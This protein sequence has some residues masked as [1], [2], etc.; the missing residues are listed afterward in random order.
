MSSDHIAPWVLVLGM[1]LCLGAC[2]DVRRGEYWREPSGTD[3]SAGEAEADSAG[4][5]DEDGDTG[6]T[7]GTGPTGGTDGG[8]A[9]S[10]GPPPPSFASDVLPL[11]R[12]DC[13]EC[14]SAGG[15]ASDSGYL[16]DEDDQTIYTTTLELVDLDQPA[17]SRLLTKAAGQGHNGGVIFDEDTTAYQTI[18]AWIEQGANP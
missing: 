9:D 7:G 4:E 6:D 11:L 8:T 10:G 16:L 2:A 3:T 13:Q 1:G 18:L 14:H 5:D 15:E 12:A 17:S